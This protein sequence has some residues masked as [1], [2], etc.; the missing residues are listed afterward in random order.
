MEVIDISNDFTKNIQQEF[1]DYVKNA[2]ITHA[3]AGMRMFIINVAMHNFSVNNGNLV[4]YKTANA[5]VIKITLDY[6]ENEGFSISEQDIYN[7]IT[8]S[9]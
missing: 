2:I 8:I 5:D 3:K 4:S 9:W 7:G 1:T 6:L